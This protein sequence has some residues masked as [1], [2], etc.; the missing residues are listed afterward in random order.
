MNLKIVLLVAFLGT[1]NMPG[2]PVEASKGLDAIKEHYNYALSHLSTDQMDNI[3]DLKAE[4]CDAIGIEFDYPF[5]V[6]PDEI[7]EKSIA[8]FLQQ[9]KGLY[10]NESSDEN[11]LAKFRNDFDTLFTSTCETIR[12]DCLVT[13]TVYQLEAKSNEKFVEVLRGDPNLWNWIQNSGLCLFLSR[14]TSSTI[15]K[16]YERFVTHSWT[17]YHQYVT[18]VVKK[19]MNKF[20][21]YYKQIDMNIST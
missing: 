15:A 21:R 11:G 4:I 14:Q 3:N 20:C 13:N 1:I 16:S 10:S 5:I 7:L 9:K 12:L 2:A 8:K 6:I 17:N 19:R 18:L